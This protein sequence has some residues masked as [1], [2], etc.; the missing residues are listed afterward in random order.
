MNSCAVYFANPGFAMMEQILNETICDAE[1][2]WQRGRHDAKPL[3]I[4]VPYF[5]FFRS[6]KFHW[7]SNDPRPF[8]L[9]RCLQI[10]VGVLPIHDSLDLKNFIVRD[11]VFTCAKNFP[12][13]FPLRPFGNHPP[14]GRL[15]KQLINLC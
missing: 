8:D 10:V 1:D 6:F 9:K 14:P 3:L 4:P 15:M 11:R 5:R 2:G 13:F 7:A 12:A